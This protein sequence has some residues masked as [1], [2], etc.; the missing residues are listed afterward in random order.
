MKM[1]SEAQLVLA[2]WEAA[3][4][5]VPYN[6]RAAIAEDILFAFVD[7]GFEAEEI[8][9][10]VDEDPSLAAAFS[11]VFPDEDDENEPEDDL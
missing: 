11:H 4:D 10:I 7:F 9:T 1:S 6:K 8:S 5:H 2:V 3:R